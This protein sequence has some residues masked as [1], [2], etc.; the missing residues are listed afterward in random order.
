M[1]RVDF[2]KTHRVRLMPTIVFFNTQGEPVYRHVG[3][4]A[5]PQEFEWLGEY[6]VSGH[7]CKQ[8]FA[9]FKMSKRKNL[10]P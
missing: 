7:T 3:M 5:D 4:I 8:N 10:A 6:V 1:S 2:A 9:T